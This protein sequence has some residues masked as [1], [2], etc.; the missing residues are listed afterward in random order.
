MN[1][2]LRRFNK[3]GVLLVLIIWIILIGPAAATAAPDTTSKYTCLLDIDSGQVI[4]GKNMN[5]PRPAASTTKMMTAILAIEYAGLSETAVVSS[6]ADRTPEY[7]IGLPAGKKILTEDLLKAAMIR[8]ANDAAVVLAE[9]VAGDEALFAHLMSVKAFAVGAV[10]TR[11]ANAS[12]LPGGSQYSTAYD[13][14]VIGRVLLANPYLKTLVGSPRTSFQHPGYREPLVIT[15]TNSLLHSYKGASGIKTGTT[16]AAGKCLVASAARQGR[17]LIAVAL[18]SGDR[19]GDCTRLLDYGFNRTNRCQVLDHSDAFKVLP[20]E[21]GKSSEIA[22][23][24]AHDVYLWLS[25]NGPNIEKVV[26]LNY[27]IKAPVEL[28]QILGTIALYAEGKPIAV[29]PLISHD[30]YPAGPSIISRIWRSLIE[31]KNV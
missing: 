7:T 9:H 5:A 1:R 2:R 12:G 31:N 17:G 3:P 25:D 22:L 30:D 28:G 23:Y 24:P 16:D 6:H 8:S 20:L 29:V 10:R 11:F 13:L 21:G 15:N 26:H 27:D 19:A 18:Q 14:A 4:Y